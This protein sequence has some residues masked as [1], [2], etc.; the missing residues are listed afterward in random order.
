[1]A[2]PDSANIP[3]PT[4]EQ[5]LE[6]FGTM[7]LIRQFETRAGELCRK[8]EMPAFLHLYIG[9]EATAAG[10][11]CH[12]RPSDCFTSTHR[13]HG[14]ALAKCAEPKRLMAELFGR[15]T[16]F[17]G[18]RGG[19]MHIFAPEIGILGTN[20]LVG[21]GIPAAVGAALSAKLRGTDDVAV[22]FFGDGAINHGAFHESAN[23]AATW[24]APCVLVCENNLYATATPLRDVT[25]NP[26]IASRAAAYGMPGESVDGQDVLAVRD[27]AGRAIE[28]A[29]SGGGPTLIESKTYRFVGHHEGDPPVGVYRTADEI[30]EWKKRDPLVLMQAYLRARWDVSADEMEGVR[31]KVAQVIE[32]AV[33]YARSSPWP[34][35]ASL[36]DHVFAQAQP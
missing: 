20:G 33:A 3:E 12:L 29:R 32:E 35:V 19:S 25:R 8:G 27:V 2:N 24:N 18:G 23:L 5:A 13:G 26:D 1:M 21:G 17:S 11:C 4:K 7:V 22:S 15:A 6:L 31:S 36:R 14:H 10:V 16:G 9:E 28:R 30:E 34:D